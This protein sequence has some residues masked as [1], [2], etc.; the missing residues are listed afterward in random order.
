MTRENSGDSRFGIRYLRL[1]LRRVVSEHVRARSR[2][3]RGVDPKNHCVRALAEY[4][5]AEIG[6]HV[7]GTGT[8]P[9][10]RR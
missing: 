10:H 2:G 8:Q 6:I 5:V 4:R 3:T 7:L 1:R 9:T